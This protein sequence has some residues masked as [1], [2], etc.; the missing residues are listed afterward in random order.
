M[1]IIL[2]CYKYFINKMLSPRK[3]NLPVSPVKENSRDLKTLSK[4]QL[5]AIINDSDNLSGKPASKGIENNKVLQA[6]P[7]K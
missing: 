6:S 3:T 2:I 1:I 4:E 5:I 7:R